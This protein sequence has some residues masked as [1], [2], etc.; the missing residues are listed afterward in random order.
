MSHPGLLRAPR[1]N[2]SIPKSGIR[3]NGQLATAVLALC[4]TVTA[5]AAD[6]AGKWNASSR[7]PDGQDMQLVFNS[8]LDGDKIS[9]TVSGDEMKLK[10]DMGN[11]SMDMTAK[12][13]KS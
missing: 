10:V 11:N 1:A 13:A 4:F 5:F 9:G 12:R 2:Y 8:K 6:I 3:G 7:T